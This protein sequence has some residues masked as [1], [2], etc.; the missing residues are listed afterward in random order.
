[1]KNKLMKYSA[2]ALMVIGFSMIIFSF[3]W[4]LAAWGTMRLMDQSVA[5]LSN[6]LFTAGFAVAMIAAVL[7]FV[8]EEKDEA[9][10]NVK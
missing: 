8:A 4:F 1:M 10:E 6:L 5:N 7:S 3:A 2:K 9:K